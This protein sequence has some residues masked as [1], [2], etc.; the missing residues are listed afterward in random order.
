MDASNDRR[1]IVKAAD[2]ARRAA[3]FEWRYHKRG[4][5]NLVS[6]ALWT[7]LQDANVRGWQAHYAYPDHIEV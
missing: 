7:A 1:L 3:W 5:G 4:F 6:D 2:A